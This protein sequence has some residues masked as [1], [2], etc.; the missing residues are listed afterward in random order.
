MLR[1]SVLVVL[2]AATS[3]A[4]S[5]GGPDDKPPPTGPATVYVSPRG[6]D[7]A[8]GTREAPF[9]TIAHALTISGAQAIALSPGEYVEGELTISRRIAVL[10]PEEGGAVLTG[11]VRI[12]ADEVVLSRADVLRGIDV[13]HAKGV[14]IDNLSIRPGEGNDA[15]GIS[16]STATLTDLSITCG[17]ETCVQIT[18]STVS[19]RTLRLS[20]DSSAKRGLRAETSSVTVHGGEISGTNTNQVLAST[21]TK[22]TITDVALNGAL[23]VGLAAVKDTHLVAERVRITAAAKMGLLASGSRV[24]GRDVFIGSAAGIGVGVTGA[25]CDLIGVSIDPM[26]D[27]SITVAALFGRESQLRLMGGHIRHGA[28]SGVAIAAGDV[29]ITGTRFTG[30]PSATTDSGD[31]IIAAGPAAILRVISAQIETPAGSGVSMTNNASGTITATISRPKVAGVFIEGVAGVPLSIEGSRIERCK[32]ESG[33]AIFNSTEINVSRTRVLGCPEAGVLAG[34]GS[35]VNVRRSSFV[36][37][38]QWGLSAFGGTTIEVS[39][40]FVSGSKWATLATC[41][42]GSSIDDAGGNKFFGP[43]TAC[44]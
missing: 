15:L 37:N 32:S 19:A 26:G 5:N 3:C 17:P 40:S 41:G 35:T 43:V 23:G 18:T 29:T 11:R 14:V 31:A 16:S 33:I 7:Q 13:S 38:A 6:D 20:G 28:K 30:D 22:M 2:F 44:P 39:D 12:T 9:R 8:A 25:D 27:S 24:I 36:D 1:A 10:G 21:R 34:Q 42:D 4:S